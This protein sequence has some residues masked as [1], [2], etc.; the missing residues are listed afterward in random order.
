MLDEASVKETEESSRS[1]KPEMSDM[2]EKKEESVSLS[3]D[4]VDRSIESTLLLS[5]LYPEEGFDSSNIV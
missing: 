2:S 3:M 4:S 5:S 1:E